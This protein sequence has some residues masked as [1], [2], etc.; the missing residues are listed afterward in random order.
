MPRTKPSKPSH[1]LQALLSRTE[2]VETEVGM[3]RFYISDSQ[4]CDESLDQDTQGDSAL[5]LMLSGLQPG[6]TVYDVGCRSGLHSLAFAKAVGPKGMV[7]CFEHDI[8]Q[9][10]LAHINLT[11]HGLDACA[12]FLPIVASDQFGLRRYNRFDLNNNDLDPRNGID[13][14]SGSGQCI[15]MPLDQLGDQ[16]SPQLI[17][18]G[19]MGLELAALKG[20]QRLIEDA[21][22]RLFVSPESP[23]S[24]DEIALYLSQIG[25]DVYGFSPRFK[26][27]SRAKAAPD[28]QQLDPQDF[29]LYCVLPRL[30]RAPPRLPL[31]MRA[32]AMNFRSQLVVAEDRES[33]R[34]YFEI[35][36]E[37]DNAK[38]VANAH[39]AYWAWQSLRNELRNFVRT[40]L[41]SALGQL[42]PETYGELTR[43]AVE[44][45]S[46]ETPAREY[47]SLRSL[48]FQAN[49]SI[50]RAVD[51]GRKQSEELVALEEKLLNQ[52]GEL[53]KFS[54]QLTQA[55][56]AKSNSDIEIESVQKEKEGL[57]AQTIQLQQSVS[58]L[59]SQ[60]LLAKETEAKS[61]EI[62]ATTNARGAAELMSV[63]KA[64]KQEIGHLESKIASLEGENAS[65]TSRAEQLAATVAAAMDA[66]EQEALAALA[67]ANEQA[68]QIKQLTASVAGA[69]DAKEQEALAALALANEQAS[70]IKQLTASVAAAM[71]AKEQVAL[72]ALALA[73]EQASQIK[74]LT[75]SV[76]AA[77]DAKEQEALAALALANEQASQIEQLE[78]QLIEAQ[79]HGTLALRA[80]EAL[81]ETL[82]QKEGEFED[83]KAGFE[84]E[85]KKLLQDQSEIILR[86]RAAE[87]KITNLN[88]ALD[89]EIQEKASIQSICS[90]LD[91]RVSELTSELAALREREA[92][93]VQARKELDDALRQKEAEFEDAKAGFEVEVKKL[94]QD[95]NEII[96]R[97]RAAED[98]ITN[99]NQALDAE[100]QEKASVQSLC[101]ELD[102]RVSELTSELA[103]LREREALVVQAR[104]EL[105]DALRQKEA[106]FESAKAGFDFEVTKLLQE[107]NEI[108]LR[109]RAAEDKITE[110][111]QY[112]D[113]QIEEKA[114]IQSLY[115]EL[116]SRISE[117]ANELTDLRSREQVLMQAQHDLEIA[118]VHNKA[119]TDKVDTL[120]NR[121][122]EGG[123]LAEKNLLELKQHFSAH[124]PPQQ[125][126]ALVRQ[127]EELRKRVEAMDAELV[128][129]DMMVSDLTD[130]V[131]LQAAQ[132][133]HQAS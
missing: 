1:D 37:A 54:Y 12:H 132:L 33:S 127:T 84:I 107:Q 48:L 122:Q 115:S 36:V 86:G 7:M 61:H 74:Q 55:S 4:R 39:F 53:S 42:S 18:I 25:Y 19:P 126:Q 9:L 8:F 117:L 93:V 69:M 103:A 65:L 24:H 14:L 89:A 102:G 29:N 99:L 73:N 41:Q 49:K 101:S 47:E 20:M 26:S 120:R 66:K 43:Q 94:L 2:V 70:Q 81:E 27:K 116:N 128:A 118:E 88:Q 131:R 95:Q 45:I 71:D 40:F 46:C 96:L 92:L 15:A 52:A 105:D 80:R 133:E 11:D 110:L 64:H 112:L 72:A 44:F 23:N 59:T 10:F 119:L 129:R 17:R 67:L 123:L 76:A 31:L 6:D 111:N 91:G 125:Y 60:L 13:D 106:E 63:S 109:G 114:S 77:M 56:I 57:Y 16:R 38:G 121:V 35:E 98:Q 28:G 3:M 62:L 104:K 113:A 79:E 97:G 22:P 5:S 21:Q 100:I 58:E 87:D 50:R 83:A 82:R 90:E 108:I 34:P 124:V 130:L 68:S 51:E 32:Q 78:L 85:V 75:A 30:H